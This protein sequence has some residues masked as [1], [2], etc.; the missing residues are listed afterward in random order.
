MSESAESQRGMMQRMRRM[1]TR[2]TQ[3]KKIEEE[4][5]NIFF[6]GISCIR[7]IFY[8]LLNTYKD[9]YKLLTMSR[10]SCSDE[11]FIKGLISSTKKKEARKVLFP[12][13]VRFAL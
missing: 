1:N 5:M 3:T 10:V 13:L 4:S 11:F 7:K 8:P 2:Q 12:L 9:S 6:D